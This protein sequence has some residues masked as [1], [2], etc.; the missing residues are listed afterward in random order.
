MGSWRNSLPTAQQLNANANATANA[1]A[2]AHHQQKQQQQPTPLSK[3]DPA[4]WKVVVPRRPR[5]AK[6]RQ[7][8]KPPAATENDTSHP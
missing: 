1:N 3:T 2:N 8:A 5:K 7:K 4:D 6:M